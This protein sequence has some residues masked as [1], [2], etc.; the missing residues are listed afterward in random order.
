MI[1]LI[2]I[3]VLNQITGLKQTPREVKNYFLRL[4]L[5]LKYD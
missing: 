1:D 5:I 2:N 4:I 3:G